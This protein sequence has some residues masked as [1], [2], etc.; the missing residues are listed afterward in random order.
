MEQSFGFFSGWIK[1][2]GPGLLIALVMLYGLYRLLLRIGEKVGIKIIDALE[3]PAAA[4]DKQ[5]LA[6]D[7]LT[8]TF[9]DYVTC[10]R[11][12]HREIIILQKI[13]LEKIDRRKGDEDGR[14]K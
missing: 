12:E 5:A 9:R 13:I 2:W 14:D 10:D 8:D 11:A 4:L 6:M 7:R 3:K 1:D